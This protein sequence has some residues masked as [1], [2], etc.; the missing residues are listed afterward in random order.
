[1]TCWLKVF[2][3]TVSVRNSS[4]SNSCTLA[5]VERFAP[6]GESATA[7]ITIVVSCSRQGRRMQRSRAS[8]VR[9][10]LQDA[11]RG[12]AP[13]SRS[14]RKSETERGSASAAGI[15]ARLRRGWR[16]P[17]WRRHAV[18]VLVVGGNIVDIPDVV[19]GRDY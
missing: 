18:W 12:D 5:R 8:A 10:V 11:D 17:S 14:R 19:G 9:I 3:A 6:Q 13:V 2:S 7:K 15:P 4:S 1:M 16:W